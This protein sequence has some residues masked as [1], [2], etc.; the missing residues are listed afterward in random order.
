M[1]PK[2]FVSSTIID[3][4][5]LRGSL[6][7][8]LE[9]LGFEVQ[10]SEYPNFKIDTDKTNFEICLQN[11]Q[12]CQY[13]ILLIGYRRGGWYEENQLSI[14][15]KEFLTAKSLIENGHPIRIITFIRKSLW[16][17]KNDREALIKQ[18]ASKSEELSQI[19]SETGSTVIDDPQ[20]I[21][22]F[23][24]QVSEGIQLSQNASPVDNWIFDFSSFEDIIVAL[25]HT[26]NIAE[27]LQTK[28]I[29]KLLLQELKYNFNKFL[30]PAENRDKSKKENIEQECF[31]N[32]FERH[33]K[34]RL[35]NK[36][37]DIKFI[38]NPLII[39]GSEIG[40]LYLYA[41]I[42]PIQL[43]VRDLKTKV[44]ERAIL[45]GTLLDYKIESNDFDTN[46]ITYS[47][48]KIIEW[49]EAYKQMMG[50]DVYK[51]FSDEIHKLASDGSAHLPSVQLSLT[52]SATL[53]ALIRH[54]RI[55]PLLGALIKVFENNEYDEILSYWKNFDNKIYG[56]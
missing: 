54:S 32:Y 10:M 41:A 18:I 23:I 19:V 2:I 22:N 39:A 46:L 48:E 16:L 47:L 56:T 8:Y 53:S 3:F 51:T 38:D 6:K 14:T 5:D 29:K 17:L 43:M 45:E 1:K 13:F 12:S 36:E 33:F 11:L 49:I 50:I 31:L 34:D 52:V 4:E 30:V 40:F 21:F 24:S 35:Y 15:H 7:Y 44:I 9:E 20:Y 28:R 25:R 55:H 42:Y 37:G 27:N 26:F